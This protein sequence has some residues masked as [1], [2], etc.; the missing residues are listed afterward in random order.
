MIAKLYLEALI[1]NDKSSSD[2]PK[3]VK[4]FTAQER[5]YAAQQLAK[6]VGHSV[7]QEEVKWKIEIL[8]AILS[9]TLFEMKQCHGPLKEIPQALSH[10][11]KAETKEI[12]FRA[13]DVKAKNFETM[14][15]ILTSTL[16]YTNDLMKNAK[17]ASPLYPMD[18]GT[19]NVWNKVFKTVMKLKM[20][21]KKESKVFQLLFTHM[22]FQLFL[23]PVGAGEII[24][25][26]YICAEESEKSAKSKNEDEPKWVE[27]VVDS[28]ISL[29]S[30]NKHVLRQ[31]VNTVMALLCPHITVSALQA[32]IEVIDPQQDEE[33]KEQS[34]ENPEDSDYEDLN[35]KENEADETS[36]DDADETSDDD[37][38]SSE[39]ENEKPK[40]DED[41]KEKVKDALGDAKAESDDDNASIDMDDLDD[42]AMEKMDTA[43]GQL[44]KQISGKKSQAQ[45][46]KE[47]KDAMAQMHFKIRCLDIID[48]YISHQPKMSHVVFLILPLLKAIETY[49][50]SKDQQPLSSRLKNT[51]K[52]ITSSKKVEDADEELEPSSLVDMLRSLIDLSNSSS[53]LVN[54]LSQ[55]IPLY[56]ECCTLILKFTQK[57]ND[58]KVDDKILELYRSS[59]MTFFN[60]T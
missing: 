56:A 28:L 41:F 26:L 53:A 17:L 4:I 34:D 6:L 27:V 52:K 12:F 23:D 37:D 2:E 39:D 50:N 45:K 3:N 48:V 10:S 5:V 8:T 16:E 59:L 55:P 13:L 1:G 58:K 40:I 18:E 57:L 60:K 33:D 38:D 22:G 25:D 32:V 46:K 14:C 30:Q 31:V 51:L 35:D 15:S 47:K 36:D 11:A 54:E 24:D 7:M 42:E 49:M 21:S 20:D 19:I 9:L 44:F 29:M 43:L